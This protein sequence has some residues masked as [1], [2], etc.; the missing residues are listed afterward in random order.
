MGFYAG[1]ALSLYGRAQDRMSHVLVEDKFEPVKDFFYPTLETH[2][3]TNRDGKVLD[4]KEAIVWLANVEFVRMKDAIKDKHQLKGKD[5]EGNAYK[6]SDVVKKINGS[7]NDVSLKINL[8]DESIL[9][10]E[11]FEIKDLP[12]REFALLHWFAD[13]RKK[14]LTGLLRQE[15]MQIVKKVS[16]K[17]QLIYSNLPMSLFNIMMI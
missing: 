17:K 8:H 16:Q 4:A 11:K 6:F 14:G 2:F 1:Y 9:V 12:P 3:V 7:F 5:K 13:Y 10:N 15:Q